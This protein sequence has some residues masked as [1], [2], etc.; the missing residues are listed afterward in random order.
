MEY[1]VITDA[2]LPEDS[3]VCV[4]LADGGGSLHAVHYRGPCLSPRTCKGVRVRER[5][6]RGP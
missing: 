2:L 4:F 5:H 3:G 1:A 6:C